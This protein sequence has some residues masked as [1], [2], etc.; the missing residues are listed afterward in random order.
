MRKL[1]TIAA[2][3]ILA[4]GNL[5]PAFAEH[6]AAH[7]KQQTADQHTA[8][9]KVA[10]GEWSVAEACNVSGFY[11]QNNID[12]CGAILEGQVSTSA[13]VSFEQWRQDQLD[14]A[15]AGQYS[16]V[17]PLADQYSDSSAMSPGVTVIPET[18]GPNLTL[19]SLGGGLLLV[20]AGL[21]GGLV[22]RRIIR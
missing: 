11:A 15:A 7:V 19:L 10:S 6:S 21:G 20:G 4:L 22:A 13:G 1:I 2:A 5:S 3:M 12:T 17:G 8:E 9:Q 18:G 16:I 14:A